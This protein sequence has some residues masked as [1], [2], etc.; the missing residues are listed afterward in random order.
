[1]AKLG[2]QA[3][4]LVSFVLILR[5][6]LL[7]YAQGLQFADSLARICFESNE[8]DFELSIFNNLTRALH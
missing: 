4:L 8:V 3:V 6:L 2:L 7:V 5:M 1:M